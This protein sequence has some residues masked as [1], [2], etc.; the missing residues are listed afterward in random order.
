M[1][2][3]SKGAEPSSFLAWK[4]A[5]PHERYK[6]LPEDIRQTI[7]Q[8]ALKEQFFLCAYCCQ[9]IEAIDDCHNEHV[10][11]QKYNPNRT[12]DFLNIV[13]SCNILNQ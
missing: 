11:S 7:R 1:R 12:L 2:T 8:Y 3:I 4:R 6:Q 5:N 10:E 13:A 9:R